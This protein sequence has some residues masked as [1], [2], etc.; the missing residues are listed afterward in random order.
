[1]AASTLSLKEAVEKHRLKDFIA[2]Q[3]ASALG[4]ADA[5]RFDTLIK[6]AIKGPPPQGRTSGSRARGGSSGKKI[7]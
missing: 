3:E 7:R 2:Q 5:S 4:K 6:E 1:M